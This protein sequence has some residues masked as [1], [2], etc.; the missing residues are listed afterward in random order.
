MT[1][2]NDQLDYLNHCR[3]K[4]G[5]AISNKQWADAAEFAKSG[6]ITLEDIE[7]YCRASAEAHVPYKK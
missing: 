7:K 6:R 2:L 1:N 4:M 5:M 3:I